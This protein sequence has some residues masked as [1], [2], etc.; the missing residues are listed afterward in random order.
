M[1]VETRGDFVLHVH[2]KLDDEGRSL[3]EACRGTGT[4]ET[5]G[6]SEQLRPW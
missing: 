4:V 5:D 2:S 3:A 1:R 6:R